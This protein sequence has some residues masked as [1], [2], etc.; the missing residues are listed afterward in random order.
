MPGLPAH[1]ASEKINIDN[2]GVISDCFNNRDFKDMA[3]KNYEGLKFIDGVLILL[4][5]H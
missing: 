1:P 2:N 5:I 3:T 4:L